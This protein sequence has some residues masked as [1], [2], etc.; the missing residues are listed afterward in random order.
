[1]A[2]NQTTWQPGWN[3]GQTTTIRVPKILVPQIMEFARKLDE[4][5]GLYLGQKIILQGMDSFIELKRSRYHPNQFSRALNTDTRSWDALR[6]FKRIVESK[7]QA[8]FLIP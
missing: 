2:C 6:E 5:E 8:L 4:E 7:P 3:T 1:M